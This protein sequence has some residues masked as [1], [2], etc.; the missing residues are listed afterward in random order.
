MRG[1]EVASPVG[2]KDGK[3]LMREDDQ[4][5]SHYAIG[6]GRIVP[7]TPYM[8]DILQADWDHILA[9]DTAWKKANGYL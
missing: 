9:E 6:W 2:V 7:D 5:I 1:M 3:V 4:T 8:V